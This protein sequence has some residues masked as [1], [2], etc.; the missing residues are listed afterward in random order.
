MEKTV[1]N[2]VA[3]RRS[4]VAGAD[5]VKNGS[6]I[7]APPTMRETYRRVVGEVAWS[8]EKYFFREELDCADVQS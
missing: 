8:G 1:I 2:Q 3:A 6:R 5:P 7:D 4:S